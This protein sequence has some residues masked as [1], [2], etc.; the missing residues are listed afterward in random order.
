M[1][2]LSLIVNL[3]LLL[4][5]IGCKGEIDPAKVAQDSNASSA[6]SASPDTQASE[7]PKLEDFDA[8]QARVYLAMLAPIFAGRALSIGE[9]SRIEQYK[10]ESIAQILEQ[11]SELPYFVSAAREYISTLI[12]TS[13][14]RDGINYNLPAH[15]AAYIVNNNLP[16]STIIT[17]DSCYD[18]Q[19][20]VI[21][22]GTG[23]PYNAGIFTTRAFMAK[24]KGHFNLPRARK[25]INAF[26]CLTYP[27]AD[28]IQPRANKDDLIELFQSTGPED[29]E[30]PDNP[31][32]F[33]FGTA[34]YTCH[35]QFAQ[36]AQLF[37]RFDT[38]GLW[39][40]NVT[41]L[42]DPD[43]MLGESTNG[44]MTSHFSDPGRAPDESTNMFG[45]GVANL[46]EATA[47]LASD[48]LFPSCTVRNLV[49]FAFG[50]QSDFSMSTAVRLAITTKAKA[51]NADPRLGDLFIETFAHPKVVKAVIDPETP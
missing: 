46:A 5:C 9:R 27:M 34:C 38:D 12:S 28:D 26:A 14:S 45:E 13:G 23:A 25:L 36:Q 37:V 3:G 50:Q 29:Q 35:G 7:G 16:W 10:G 33:G 17:S 31:I 18:W 41:G 20:E 1:R 6:A 44:L 15:L 48:D 19:G 2:S 39:Q 4:G 24:H 32:D 21:D 11:W 49:A 40:A 47:K 30:D 42:Q 43:A 8:D 22:C 51:R